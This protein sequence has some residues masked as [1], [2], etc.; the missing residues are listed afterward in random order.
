ME[1]KTVSY[2]KGHS[3][4]SECREVHICLITIICVGGSK[5]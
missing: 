5:S 2:Y 4:R 3:S 1:K